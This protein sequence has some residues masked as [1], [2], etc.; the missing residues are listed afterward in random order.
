M[1]KLYLL[2]TLKRN[3]KTTNMELNMLSRAVNAKPI[4]NIDFIFTWITQN[5]LH[6]HTFIFT[7]QIY[8]IYKFNTMQAKLMQAITAVRHVI[9]IK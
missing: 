3:C 7:K 9:F 8:L 5:S 4:A 6:K 2:I 1:N